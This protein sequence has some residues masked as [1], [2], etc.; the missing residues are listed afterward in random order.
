MDQEAYERLLADLEEAKGSFDIIVDNMKEEGIEYPYEKLITLINQSVYRVEVAIG[1]L[2]DDSE[3][4]SSL[5]EK[6]IVLIRKLKLIEAARR[7]LAV[8]LIYSASILWRTSDHKVA[9]YLLSV[10]GTFCAILGIDFAS[11]NMRYDLLDKNPENG[12]VY[13]RLNG[14]KS[15]YK[16]NYKMASNDIDTIQSINRNLWEELEKPRA[17][18]L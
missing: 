16:E 10:I 11:A 17:I 2:H 3:E 14:L 7:V 1:K 13:S 9:A 6:N 8:V 15:D 4:Y 5:S 12:K 18:S